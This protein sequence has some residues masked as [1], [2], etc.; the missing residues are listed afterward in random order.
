MGWSD[1]KRLRFHRPSQLGELKRCTSA[2]GKPSSPSELSR[3]SW[4]WTVPLL[5]RST[6][7]RHAPLSKCAFPSL[8]SPSLYCCLT[9]FW[10]PSWQLWQFPR[11]LGYSTGIPIS[12]RSTGGPGSFLCL[13]VFMLNSPSP[14]CREGSLTLISWHPNRQKRGSKFV[15]LLFRLFK[16]NWPVPA[17]GRPSY[18]KCETRGD[19][20]AIHHAR[21]GPAFSSPLLRTAVR[22]LLTARAGPGRGVA[23][24]SCR[25]CCAGRP[26]CR[27]TPVCLLECGFRRP[28]VPSLSPIKVQWKVPWFHLLGLSHFRSS[29]ACKMFAVSH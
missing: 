8:N 21:P 15:S 12:L 4:L 27:T 3:A 23:S 6:S 11:F 22:S 18:F 29:V 13:F 16:I 7:S 1:Q 9:G 26:S 10:S 28:L 24:D 17:A 5:K 20:S 14:F 19:R 2:T 25:M